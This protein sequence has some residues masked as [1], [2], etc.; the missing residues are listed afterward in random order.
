MVLILQGNLSTGITASP[1]TDDV[2]D[3]SVGNETVI[4]NFN[5]LQNTLTSFFIDLTVYNDGTYNIISNLYPNWE[6]FT[7]NQ[8]ESVASRQLIFDN[9]SKTFIIN[10]NNS[11]T[12]NMIKSLKIINYWNIQDQITNNY[13]QV[14]NID[15]SYNFITFKI[16]LNNNV[17][18]YNHNVILINVWSY[19]NSSFKR[20]E[21]G[22]EFIMYMC[23][24]NSF[25]NINN[26]G[27]NGR[28]AWLNASKLYDPIS[29]KYK[30]GTGCYNYQTPK[31]PN[32]NI[33][34]YEIYVPNL[35]SQSS[36]AIYFKI[37]L[38]QDSSNNIAKVTHTLDF[39]N[40]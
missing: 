31:Y 20:L 11:V 22:N 5:T 23:E 33:H 28:T 32:S 25:Y 19:N 39:T 1:I 15:R 21:L 40:I 37:G 6:N 17:K 2:Q 13:I 36:T 24:F 18:R 34:D 35:V 26:S 10:N 7:S 4:N 3:Y 27:F 14:P 9:N 38:P 29:F 16:E 12:S 8:N 30:S